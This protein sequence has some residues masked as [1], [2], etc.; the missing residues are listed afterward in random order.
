MLYCFMRLCCCVVGV[1]SVS[2]IVWKL[3]LVFELIRSVDVNVVSVFVDFLML[4]FICD[5]MRLYLSQI[6]QI[7]KYHNHFALVLL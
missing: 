3:V 2:S 7:I 4:S 1:V 6:Y 5:V